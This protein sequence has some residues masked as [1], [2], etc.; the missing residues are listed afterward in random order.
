ML[1]VGR[2]IT[3]VQGRVWAATVDQALAQIFERY[4]G[5]RVSIEAVQRRRELY[6]F[7]FTAE[8]KEDLCEESTC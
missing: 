8:L 2:E 5:A 6:W 4:P 1:R 7:E 3:I